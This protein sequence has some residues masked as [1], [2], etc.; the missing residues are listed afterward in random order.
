[1]RFD[2]VAPGIVDT[3]L[4]AQIK[5]DPEWEHAYASKSALGRWSRPSELAGGLVYPRQLGC[6]LR[7]F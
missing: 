6:F 2:A 4:T 5:A 1:M 3:P 7:I